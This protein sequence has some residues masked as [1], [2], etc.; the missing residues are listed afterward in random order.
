[1]TEGQP[2][3]TAK[4]KH[5]VNGSTA[6]KGLIAAVSALCL[7]VGVLLSLLLSSHDSRITAQES[8]RARDVADGRLESP[9]QK[10]HRTDARIQKFWTDT[11]KPEL[12]EMRAELLRALDTHVRNGH[13]KDG[14]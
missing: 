9:E 8:A 14:R 11:M 4:G 2:G 1:M 13:G 3:N 10:S 12:R 6:I 7:L 5:K